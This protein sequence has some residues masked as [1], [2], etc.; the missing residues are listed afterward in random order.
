M[1]KKR[2]AIQL[3]EAGGV[4]RN[5]N[6][7]A[8]GPSA[9]TASCHI[10]KI[11]CGNLASQPLE[12]KIAWGKRY[13]SELTVALIAFRVPEVGIFKEISCGQP[14][15]RFSSPISTANP[16]WLSFLLR[17]TVPCNMRHTT[18]SRPRRR[19]CPERSAATQQSPEKRREQT[20]RSRCH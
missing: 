19:M 6:I 4:A 12:K 7:A 3:R 9:S 8:G 10:A 18:L 14:A 16:A 15:I 11:S 13:R 2:L 20:K 5:F 17:C 1:Y